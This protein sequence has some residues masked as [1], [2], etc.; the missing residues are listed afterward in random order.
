MNT[1]LKLQNYAGGRKIFLPLSLF[2][3]AI[4]SLTGML[5]YIFI[6]FIIKELFHIEGDYSQVGITTYAWWAVGTAV[7]SVVL[8]FTAL[9]LSH[10]VA[11]RVET[12]MRWRAMQKIVRM[13]LGF[14]D[15]NSSGRI[16]KIIDDNASIT[17]TF[18]AHQLPDLAGS[19]LMPL[20]AIVLIFVFD[21]R[22]GLAC[23]VPIIIAMALMSFMM[24]NKGKKFMEN[25]MTSL[26]DMNT[27]A[28]EYV[29][30]IPVVK[31]F[32]QTVF[33]FKN[34]HNSIISYKQMVFEYTKTWENPMSVTTVVINGFVF[35][36]VPV[37][38][39]LIGYS[40]NYAL[41]LLNLFLYILLT[42][43]F[44]QG[45]MKSMYMNQALGQAK[46]AV[47]RM[48]SLTNVEPLQSSVNP[49]SITKYDIC[50]KN[51]SFSYPGAANK[52]VDSVS[53]T[54]PEGKTIALVGAS[55]SG[56]TTI[57]RLVPRFWDADTGQVCIGGTD[58]KEIDHKELMNHVSFVFQN[59]KLF[60][61]S[62]LD[63]IKYGNPDVS[64]KAVERAVDLAQC[65][66]IINKLS[67]GLDTKIGV[68]G[69]YLSGGEQQRIVL[70]RAI[71]KDAPIVVLDEAT[72]FTDPENEHLIQKA[73]GKLT[74]GKTVLLIAH[75]LTS[76]MDADIIL[77]IDES[78]IAEQGS[79]HELLNKEGIY[80]KMWNEYQQS[81]KWTIGKETQY[82]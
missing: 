45:I 30:G 78:K 15:N 42:P 53:F 63:N 14:F 55:G 26:E 7:G 8:Y 43:V 9:T 23:L 47:N 66:E 34:F 16:R 3:S 1:L 22:L 27:E 49:K 51:V 36:L 35:F 40:G 10:L 18:L 13:P 24:G 32:Q 50:F 11:F 68:E 41:V 74:K 5:P 4:S 54:I 17:H 56:K 25:Y 59:T 70:A 58:V 71:L 52:A 69:T 62:L 33:S 79:H 19:V 64:V 6:W 37:A 82:V 2:L 28:V 39:L 31:V 81:I 77:V 48:E 57:A 80:S 60:K 72:A 76:V 20:T 73:L 29:R 67:N 75:R 12:T 65:R 44:S 61:T 38:V 46:E 21:W